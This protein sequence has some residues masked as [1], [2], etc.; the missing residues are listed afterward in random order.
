[1]E[2]NTIRLLLLE[3]N[4]AD[5]RLIEIYLG[6]AFANNYLLTKATRLSEALKYLISK[7]F[8]IIVSDISLP[9][10]D[11]INTFNKIFTAAPD[12]PIIVLTGFGDQSFGIEAVKNG[13][14]DFFNK[15]HLDDNNLKRSIVYSIE[16]NNLHLELRNAKEELENR[17]MER[18]RELAQANEQMK[19]E[20]ESRK[21]IEEELIYEK[22]K[23]RKYLKIAAN[24]FIVINE[25]QEVELINKK[26]CEVLGYSSN[27]IIGKNYFDHFIPEEQKKVSKNV[28]LQLMKGEI[29]L[30][31]YNE[32]QVLTKNEPRII[33]W[34]NT[35][36]FD[37]NKKITG[38]LSSGE[39]ITYRKLYEKELNSLAL[40]S[41]ENPNPVLRVGN[42]GVICFSNNAGLVL[43][44]DWQ[45][46]VGEILPSRW[47]KVFVGVLE[48]GKIT[49]IEVK[50]GNK[51]FSLVLTPIE[52]GRYVNIYGT[53][54]TET[55][56][57]T[58]EIKTLSIA[59][60]KTENAI[61]ITNEVGE[62]QWVNEGFVRLTGYSLEEVKQT[63]GEMLRKGKATGI[64][65][66]NNN[67]YEVIHKK[68]PVSYET[69]NFRKDG[70]VYWAYTTLT[71]ILNIKGEVEK[72]IAV[73]SDITVKKQAEKDLILAKEIAEESAK[74]KESFL[75][76]MSHE[77]RTPMNAIIGILQLMQD[78]PVSLE[79]KQYINSMNFAAE[80]L[81]HIINDIL[82]ISKIE[83]GKF[84][85]EE[86]DF[87]PAVVI[88]SLIN[89]FSHQ[90]KEKNL[91]L[92]ADLDEKLPP[93]ILGDPVRLNQI[94]G[95]LISNALKFTTKGN[96]T[97]SV[98]VIEEKK[99]KIALNFLVEDTGIGIPKEKFKL[100]FEA[101]E[102][103]DKHTSRR[104]GG[105][106]LGLSIVN[107][108]VELQGGQ[109]TVN[110]E[111][112]KGT[113]FSV[114]M[115]YKKAPKKVK[116]RI[117]IPKKNGKLFSWDGIHILLV[118]DNELNQMVANKFLK[119]GG[120]EAD[121]ASNGREA[122]EKLK[123]SD[124]DLVL[125]DIQMPEM[126][127]YETTQF[128]RKNFK[129]G[130]EK[131]LIMAMTA[132]AFNDEEKKCLSAGMNGYISKPLNREALFDKMRTL[133]ENKKTIKFSNRNNSSLNH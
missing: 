33:A 11:G 116:T 39:D 42:N 86:I 23:L 84:E 123:N 7:K 37:K 48:S 121:I 15:N 55:R 132:H 38:I 104:Y 117:L 100:I 10:S 43:L 83:S 106:G 40:F 52:D 22:E 66:S 112:D 49:E 114:T 13:A 62:I 3:D 5:A 34:H 75:A 36:V 73:D 102:Q 133:L 53:D 113:V 78:T 127:G 88:N 81:L 32:N 45:T 61:V 120:V 108:L 74:A 99:N 96:I 29:G 35:L 85:I 93:I 50:C 67:Y 103:A 47:R 31:E 8:D 54:V 24:I 76:N 14:A 1:M 98:K 65:P 69:K 105:T 4:P 80:N 9:D 126:N 118:E 70:T 25:N 30:E 41:S 64:D 124:Y 94:I 110:S 90:A 92:T 19:L 111:V 95:N 131:I 51:I 58:D 56:K 18:T 28:F 59:V 109:I 26:G 119:S 72:I 97:L 16:R 12:I 79:Q 101:F 46:K 128:I 82:D 71:P 44:N 129:G 68:H 89:Y 57:A 60:S 91:S 21:K 77:I 2:S 125:M 87:N 20:I 130:K 17:V 6:E 115:H 27:E 63:S 107:H 122:I